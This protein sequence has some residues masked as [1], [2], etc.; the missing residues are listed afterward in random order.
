M[1]INFAGLIK[2]PAF[3]G[4][5]GVV[6]AKVGSVMTGGATW[7]SIILDLVLAAS[8][9]FVTHQAVTNTAALHKAGLINK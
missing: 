9:L 1:N 5:L 3:Y 6:I 2:N 8:G 4:F 7:V